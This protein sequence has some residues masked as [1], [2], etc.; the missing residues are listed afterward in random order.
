MI[1]YNL[2]SERHNDMLGTAHFNGVDYTDDGGVDWAVLAFK[3]HS[4]RASLDNQDD[5]IDAGSHCVDA[6]DVS[7]FVF[8]FCVDES[9]HQELASVKTIILPGGDYGSNYSG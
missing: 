2:Q 5:L 1:N 9:R 7:F 6:H 8:S 3:G 4:G